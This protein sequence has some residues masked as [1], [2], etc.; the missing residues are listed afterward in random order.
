MTVAG[1]EVHP[2]DAAWLDSLAPKLLRDEYPD[3]MA[4]RSCTCEPDAVCG[5][6]RLLAR[7]DALYQHMAGLNAE[8]RALREQG[9]YERVRGWMGV[10]S[11]GAIVLTADPTMALHGE[12]F[13]VYRVPVSGGHLRDGGT[14]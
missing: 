5:A 7:Y 8:R 11:E 12:P 2:E 10:E 1:E 13:P 3:Q 14:T 6:H 9:R 4:A